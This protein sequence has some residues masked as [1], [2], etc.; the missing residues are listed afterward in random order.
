MTIA[1][2]T[3]IAL[4]DFD[5][6]AHSA[7]EMFRGVAA[8]WGI[9]PDD[10]LPSLYGPATLSEQFASQIG[11]D[12][13]VEYNEVLGLAKQVARFAY[14]DGA[15]WDPN[16]DFVVSPAIHRGDASLRQVLERHGIPTDLTGDQ[17]ASYLGAGKAI[18]LDQMFDF[19]RE[20]AHVAYAAGEAN[21]RGDD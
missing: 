18:E 20:V 14:G 4:S 9:W 5:E 10:H 6:P 1:I 21:Y 19:C 11:P 15:G 12:E 8:D 13:A 3:I 17:F 16:F 2:P 7:D